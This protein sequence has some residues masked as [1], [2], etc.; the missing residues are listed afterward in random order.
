MHTRF[1]Q[2]RATLTSLFHERENLIDGLLVA[3]LSRNHVFL[4]GAPGT[5]KSAIA[6]ALASS[7]AITYFYRLMTKTSLPEDLFGPIDLQAYERGEYRRVTTNRLP[8]ADLVVLDEVGKT[9]SAALNLLLLA[10]NEREYEDGGTVRKIPLMSLIGTSNELLT[11]EESSAINDRFLLRFF[12]KPIQSDRAFITLLQHGP[13]AMPAPIITK[14]DLQQAQADV[15]Q[16]PIPHDVIQMIA[17]LRS[18]LAAQGITA[19]DRRWVQGVRVCQAAA[20]LAGRSHVALR[21]LMWYVHL[22]WQTPDQIRTLTLAIQKLVNPLAA[23][24]LEILDEGADVAAEADK[25]NTTQASL[26][27]VNKIK[28]LLKQL[29]DLVAT[30]PSAE[31]PEEIA[32]ARA[33]L[34]TYQQTHVSKALGYVPTA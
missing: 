30:V 6:R 31:Q 15:A 2:L 11:G 10:M 12:V 34:R 33:K 24:A 29:D 20:W 13:V 22:L 18:E 7:C 17:R 32:D 28:A 8:E 21:D 25:A 5:A 23:K 9:S 27:A 16:M 4:I 3:L 19:S 1:Q 26:E 14:A